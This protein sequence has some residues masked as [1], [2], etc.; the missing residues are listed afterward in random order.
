MCGIPS[1]RARWRSGFTGCAAWR[2]GPWCCPGAASPG[3]D[4]P[5]RRTHQ[6]RPSPWPSRP[7]MTPS[8]CRGRPPGPLGGG[9][10][11]PYVEGLRLDEAMHLLSPSWRWGSTARRCPL[12]NGAPIRAGGALEVRLQEHQEH[13]LHPAGRGDAPTTWNQLA[14]N[15]YG[16]YANVNPRVDHPR[17]SQASERFIGEGASSG[18]C[19]RQPTLGCSTAMAMRWPP[20]IKRDGSAQAVL[21]WGRR[22]RH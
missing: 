21:R 7:S 9:I 4:H 11:Y 16:F 6:S 15:E 2:P 1:T 19:K 14:P 22:R 8:S 13:R 18:G 10:D 17:W 12:Q 5:P 20:S 3:G